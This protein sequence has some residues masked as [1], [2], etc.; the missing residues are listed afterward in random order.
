MSDQVL[1]THDTATSA[2]NLGGGRISDLLYTHDTATCA[3]NYGGGR[4]S[5][6]LYTHDTAT[7]ADNHGEESLSDLLYT[8]DT[9]TCANNYGGGR[10]SDLLYKTQQHLTKRASRQNEEK[11][12]KRVLPWLCL[13]KLMHSFAHSCKASYTENVKGTR[14]RKKTKGR[15]HR[16]DQG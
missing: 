3:N 10:I 14:G 5:D 1:Y 6:L 2:N 12:K 7:C 9:A 11:K 16:H 13:Q 8:H 15:V 4:I